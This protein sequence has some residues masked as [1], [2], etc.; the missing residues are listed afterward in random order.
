M[1]SEKKFRSRIKE[2]FSEEMLNQIKRIMK[3][4]ATLS[5]NE[6]FNEILNILS[7]YEFIELAA[8]TN[9]MAVLKDEYVYKIA[10][11]SY[12]VKDNWQEFNFSKELQPYVTKTYECNGLIAVAE[13]VTLITQKEF[14]DSAENI[15]AILSIL[16]KNYIFDDIGLISKNVCN[17]GFA[18]DGTLKVLDYG[19]IYKK[20]KLVMFCDKCGGPIDYDSTYSKLICGECGKKFK[21]FDLKTRSETDQSLYDKIK[22]D[23]MVVTFV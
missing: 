10:L 11:D 7:P 14:E 1:K 6:K 22:V 3:S 21:V 17:F 13:Y 9:R 16:A 15:T 19:Y 5:N 20:D 18:E 2:N 12:G 23:E 8:G 4:S